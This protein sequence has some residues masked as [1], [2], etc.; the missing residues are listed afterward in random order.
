RLDSLRQKEGGTVS[1]DSV[2]RA[3]GT[4]WTGTLTPQGRLGGLTADRGPGVADQVGAS[5]GVLFPVLP[6]AG[7]QGA[8]TWSDTAERVLKTDAFDAKGRAVA[9]YGL[10]GRGG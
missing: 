9:G 10:G 1:A 5:L 3:E 4:T 2:L 8:T 7:L 6:A